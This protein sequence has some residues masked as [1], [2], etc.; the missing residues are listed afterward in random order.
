M[1]AQNNSFILWSTIIVM[2]I[3]TAPLCGAAPIEE[4]VVTAQK[5][6]QAISEVPLAIQA[7]G[8]GQLEMRGF[9][10]TSDVIKAVPGASL[11]MILMKSHYA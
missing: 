1:K 7:L 11:L 5:R 2:S 8:E 3:G 6:A 4:I 10:E 9:V